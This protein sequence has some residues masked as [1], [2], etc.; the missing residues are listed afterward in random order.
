MRQHHG[1]TLEELE[2]CVP[3]E[4]MIY[5]ELLMKYLKEL[6]AKRANRG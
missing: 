1:W 4:R 6:E 3:F 2:S 5:V